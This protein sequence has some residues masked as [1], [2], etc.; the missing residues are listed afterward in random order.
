MSD[1]RRE[2]VRERIEAARER[3]E[4]RAGVAAREAKD[5]ATAT[6]QFV[7]EHPFAVIAGGVA[8]GGLVA[9]LWPR[10][11]RK[12]ESGAGRLS[13]LAAAAGEMAVAYATR[14]A[15]GAR[16][17]GRDGMERLEDL[18]ESVGDATSQARRVAGGIAESS[19]ER[20]TEASSEM[21]KM[22][23]DLAEAAIESAREASD[24][25]LRR[26]SEITARFRD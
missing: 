21:R 11:R 15:S 14:A 6:R 26:A 2:R 5:A 19:G 16:E 4:Q 3:V 7:Q 9:A 17:A 23:A 20:I 10:R 24:A 22:A 12:Q 8:V 1:E 25:A 18:G 13:R